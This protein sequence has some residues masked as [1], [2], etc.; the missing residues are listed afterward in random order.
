MSRIGWRHLIAKF[1]QNAKAEDG[2]RIRERKGGMLVGED[3]RVVYGE[4]EKE[5]TLSKVKRSR[6]HMIFGFKAFFRRTF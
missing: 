4:R 3:K 2:G 1:R 5:E 6:I